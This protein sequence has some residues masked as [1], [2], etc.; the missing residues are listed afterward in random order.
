MLRHNKIDNLEQICGLCGA[1]SECV[2]NR[3]DL[4]KE[5]G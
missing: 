4:L 3:S 1:F 5:L 2:D